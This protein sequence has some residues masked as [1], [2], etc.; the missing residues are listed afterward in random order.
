M[1]FAIGDEPTNEIA[2]TFGCVSK[3]VDAFASAVDDVEHAFRQAGFFEQ[4]D[5]H[6]AVS[7]TFSLGFST[8]VFP[9]ASASGNI[10]IGTIAGKLKGVMPTQTPS[11]WCIVS[12]STP[13]ARFSSVSPMSSDGAAGVFDVLDAA[14][15]AAARFGQSLA[16]FARDALADAI[17]VFFDELPVTE[18]EPRAFDRRRVAP[19]RESAAAAAS[20]ASF[21]TSAPHIGTSAITSP[22]EGL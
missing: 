9:Q 12:Q 6:H 17:E 4:F 18:E 19:A 14:I 11:G 13:R 7:G 22:R 21:T 20:T 10:H 15:N 2:F 5:E 16:M 3:R 1:Y 8:N